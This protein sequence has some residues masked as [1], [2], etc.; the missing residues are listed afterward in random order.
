MR[1]G[2]HLCVDLD[3]TLAYDN[4]GE[5]VPG[6]IGDPVPAML[7][8]VKAWRA[9]GIEVRIFTARVSTE[10]DPERKALARREHRAIEAWCQTHL[11]EV[12]PITCE[13]SWRCAALYD[14]RAYRVE[15]NTG[16]I[17]GDRYEE[18]GTWWVLVEDS[19]CYSDRSVMVRGVY[20]SPE[21][22]RDT[23][24]EEIKGWAIQPEE[25]DWRPSEY[26]GD[27]PNT[28]VL[29]ARQ[30]FGYSTDF[31]ARPFEIDASWLEYSDWQNNEAPEE[32]R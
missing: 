8:R 9:E 6:V 4:G 3:G 19:G 31:F 23:A 5:Y 17:V 2:D 26:L 30:R 27:P 12:L 22:A 20:S 11:G 24:L 1:P 32:V 25:T 16:V 10:G 7:A 29:R 18:S 15:K 14:D 28:W 21:L 13:K